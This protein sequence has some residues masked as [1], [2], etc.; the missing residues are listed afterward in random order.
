[1]RQ[2][3]DPLDAL[4]SFLVSMFGREVSPTLVFAVISGMIAIGMA[5]TFLIRFHSIHKRSKNDDEKYELGPGDE[6][7]EE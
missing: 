3:T 6:N 4:A 7:D 2:A 5:L 1:M